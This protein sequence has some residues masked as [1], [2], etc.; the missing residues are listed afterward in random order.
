MRN[1]ENFFSSYF[2]FFLALWEPRGDTGLLISGIK[3]REIHLEAGLETFAFFR[4]NVAR[5]L[6]VRHGCEIFFFLFV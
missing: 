4:H 2:F 6:R 3:E 1:A 5:Y